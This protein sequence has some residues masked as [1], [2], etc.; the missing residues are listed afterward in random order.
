MNV[1]KYIKVD[2]SGEIE[3]VEKMKEMATAN[4]KR[5]EFI[6]DP[7]TEGSEMLF[8]VLNLVEYQVQS[9]ENS[10]P[11]VKCPETGILGI[12]DQEHYEE[13][14]AQPNT[15]KDLMS[16]VQLF[17]Q[18]F[19]HPVGEELRPLNQAERLKR[20]NYM[21]EELLEFFASDNVNGQFDGLLDL[22]YFLLG[23]LIIAG[24]DGEMVEEGFLEVQASN[25]TKLDLNGEPIYDEGGKIMKGPNFK[26][27]DLDRIIE[28]YTNKTI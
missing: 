21:K 1:I 24:Y 2:I 9:K 8:S 16:N 4:P 12:Y 23:T 7:E 11:N 18:I 13:N 3:S 25:M 6:H 5:F 20:L 19:K 17:H 15:I 22:L 27:P 14:I 10:L 26:L 28:K